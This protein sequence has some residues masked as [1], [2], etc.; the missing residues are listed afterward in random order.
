MRWD[1]C[2]NRDTARGGALS[3]VAGPRTNPNPRPYLCP[4]GCTIEHSTSFSVKRLETEGAG[5][6]LGRHIREIIASN[7]VTGSYVAY[8]PQQR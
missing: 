3:G 2:R 7:E 4:Y 5:W 1:R 8:G 6:I